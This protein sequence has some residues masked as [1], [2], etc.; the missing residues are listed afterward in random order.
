VTY[1]F[2]GEFRDRNGILI[3]D[4]AWSCRVLASEASM[5]KLGKLGQE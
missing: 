4:Y 3:L 2:V 1:L 5:V